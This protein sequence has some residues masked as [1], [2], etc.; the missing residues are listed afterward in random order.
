MNIKSF[1]IMNKNIDIY[2]YKK[3]KIFDIKPLDI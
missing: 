2:Y 3:L 1:E